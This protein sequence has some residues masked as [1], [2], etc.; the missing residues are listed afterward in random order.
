MKATQSIFKTWEKFNDF[1]ME[2][3]TKLWWFHN[4]AGSK[5]QRSVSLMKEH[6]EQYAMSGN[7]FDLALWLLDEFKKDGVNAYPIGDHLM[8]EDAHAAVIAVSEDGYRYY[9]DLGDQWISP[10]LIDKKCED[11]TNEKLVGFF[12]GA[13]VQVNSRIDEFEILYHRPNGKMSKQSFNA[14][15][16]EMNNFLQAAE[17]SQN[18]IHPK[19][20]FECRLPY[21]SEIAHWE[22]YNWESFLSTNDGLFPESKLESAE[23]WADRLYKRTGYNREVLLDVLERYKRM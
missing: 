12:P 16:V 9:C 21:N 3:L 23:D 19:P 2:T 10:I 4:S 13:H 5:K 22:F 17:F 8:T 14:Q 11:F 7:C 6:R 15:P 1:H 18:I 20:L